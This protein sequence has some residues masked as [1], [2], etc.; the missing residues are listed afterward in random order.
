SPRAIW[1]DANTARRSTPPVSAVVAASV[2][3]G[4]HPTRADIGRADPISGTPDISR[5]NGIPIPSHP[6]VCGTRI[7]RRVG[8]HRGRGRRIITVPITAN[9]YPYKHM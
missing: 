7:G 4:R 8:D 1:H 3:A 5:S 9:S 2:V 6:G